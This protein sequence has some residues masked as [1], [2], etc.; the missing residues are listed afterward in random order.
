MFEKTD[1]EKHQNDPFRDTWFDDHKPVGKDWLGNDVHRDGSKS[2][3]NPL[4][5]ET[6]TWQP[7][8]WW[9]D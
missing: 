9:E 1:A 5:G 6:T 3:T 7:K 8:M 4:T 2:F